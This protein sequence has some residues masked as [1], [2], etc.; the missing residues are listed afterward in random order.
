MPNAFARR[1]GLILN[2]LFWVAL[3]E[4][5]WEPISPIPRITPDPP[6]TTSSQ[7]LI[8]LRFPTKL[9]TA[10]NSAQA[11][12]LAT[13]AAAPPDA[14][15]PAK[16]PSFPSRPFAPTQLQRV[17]DRGVAQFASAKDDAG[18]SRGANL[19]YLSAL[20]G[21]SRARELVARNYLRYPAM[22]SR[23]PVE[24]A[25]RFTVEV[26]AQKSDGIDEVARALGNDFAQRGEA[27]RFAR[28]IVDAISD[29]DRLHS[30]EQVARL[31]AI[32]APIPGV[33]AGIW[34]AIGYGGKPGDCLASLN[35][36]L[37]QYARLN[38]KTGVDRE[39]RI[40]GLRL[41]DE[42]GEMPK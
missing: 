32:F 40:R 1:I 16:A 14:P 2:I 31:L 4:V 21:Y 22:Q 8:D 34:Q 35:S 29:D 7:G 17:M 25:V 15:V 28:Y 24:D 23:V 38:G 42:A 11:E 9:E 30:P 20:L 12:V 19:V 37:L 10:G 5:V 36:E 39:G 26:V 3:V 6:Q 41:L 13:E 18:K 27:T 33:C